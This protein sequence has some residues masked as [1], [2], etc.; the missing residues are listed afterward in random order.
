MKDT[1]SIS[2]YLGSWQVYRNIEGN[3]RDLYQLL[4]EATLESLHSN[5]DGS[6]QFDVEEEA[7]FSLLQ[8]EHGSF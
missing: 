7:G 3:N 2:H 8:C 4:L 6:L 1:I 5:K